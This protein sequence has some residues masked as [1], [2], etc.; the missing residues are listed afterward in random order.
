MSESRGLFAVR[1]AETGAGADYY[2]APAESADD[3][4]QPFGLKSRVWTEGR[5]RPSNDGFATK[6]S[7]RL[8]DEV[9]YPPWLGRSL[10]SSNAHGS[11]RDC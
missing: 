4:G 3:L 8:M 6:L 10:V 2:V 7:K 1:R 11:I 9:T 5:F